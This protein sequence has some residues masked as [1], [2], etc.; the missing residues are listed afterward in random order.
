MLCKEQGDDYY[1]TKDIDLNFYDELNAFEDKFNA[2]YEEATT[3]FSLD[4]P[5][6]VTDKTKED[7]HRSGDFEY[8]C[9]YHHI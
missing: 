5:A 9:K 6:P 3:H 7:E 1:D 8:Y 4:N 2:D